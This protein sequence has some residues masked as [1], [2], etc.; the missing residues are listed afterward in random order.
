[1]RSSRCR[2]NLRSPALIGQDCRREDVRIVGYYALRKQRCFTTGLRASGRGNEFRSETTPCSIGKIE[3]S[4]ST[5]KVQ[6]E[7]GRDAPKDA[8]TF[9][10]PR[11]LRLARHLKEVDFVP[12]YVRYR[13]ARILRCVAARTISDFL[14]G[15]HG[16]LALPKGDA[17]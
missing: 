12:P 7:E 6:Q 8:P 1:M 15:L 3:C 17:D 4:G 14:A 11:Y 16:L 2:A 10:L 13:V 5:T 9:P